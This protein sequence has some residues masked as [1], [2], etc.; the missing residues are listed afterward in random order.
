VLLYKSVVS[1]PLLAKTNLVLF[2]NKCDILKTKLASGI[3]FA[4]YVVSYGDRPNDFDSVSKCAVLYRNNF[5]DAADRPLS[6]SL[7]ADLK[8]KFSG[9]LRD[10]S[11]EP[12]PF[13]CHLTSVT[14]TKTTFTILESGAFLRIFA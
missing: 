1:N 8:R 12:R 3:R 4:K 6:L 10:Y 9:L 5:K 11:P 14:D 13:Y 2:L 7:R